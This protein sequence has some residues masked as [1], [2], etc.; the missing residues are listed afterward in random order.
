[1]EASVLCC[2]GSARCPQHAVDG[3]PLGRERTRR[4]WCA[5]GDSR[6]CYPHHHRE[7]GAWGS[8]STLPAP[9]G[10]APTPA[11][12]PAAQYDATFITA[13]RFPPGAFRWDELQ[14]ARVSG[15]VPE[16]AAESMARQ[17]SGRAPRV[18]NLSSAPKKGGYNQQLR[19]SYIL[20]TMHKN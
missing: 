7:E 4:G 12:S 14:T 9:R 1:M 10:A 16:Q 5:P 20:V 11:P 15:A 19:N 6:Q 3:Q 8:G 2:V 13:V 18:P 17:P